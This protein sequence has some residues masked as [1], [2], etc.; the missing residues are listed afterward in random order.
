MRSPGR[1]LLLGSLAL[2]AN[3]PAVSGDLG[4]C[5]LPPDG[6]LCFVLERR[7]YYDYEK[8]KCL[9]FSWGGCTS[10]ENNFETR[11]QCEDACSHYG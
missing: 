4:I 2:W 7:W 11:K 8:K 6:G 5:I 9:P 1:L 3:L 10:N